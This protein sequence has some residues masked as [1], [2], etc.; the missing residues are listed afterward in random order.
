LSRDTNQQRNESATGQGDGVEGGTLQP[1][2]RRGE[3]HRKRGGR[4][5][6]RKRK[7]GAGKKIFP[8]RG[9]GGGS[10]R[11]KLH[12]KTKKKDA[13]VHEPKIQG[14]RITTKKKA[15]GLRQRDDWRYTP[16]R[17]AR[18]A[19]IQRNQRCETTSIRSPQVRKRW[20]NRRS[21]TAN[22]RQLTSDGSLGKMRSKRDDSLEAAK[23]QEGQRPPRGLEGAGNWDFGQGGGTN[24]KGGACKLRNQ[25]KHQRG[26][27]KKSR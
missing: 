20:K 16:E 24:R 18:G 1:S 9:A 15:P 6:R 14:K 5:A 10:H 26:G 4:V 8:E 21:L 12:K 17:E 19:M 3:A 11:E 23:D 25:V 7:G 22:M 13:D 2:R 27:P